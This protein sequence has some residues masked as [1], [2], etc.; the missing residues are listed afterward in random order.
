MLCYQRVTPKVAIQ[1]M[2]E[3]AIVRRFKREM[4]QNPLGDTPLVKKVS[5]KHEPVSKRQAGFKPDETP[6]Y[7]VEYYPDSIR[8]A[9]LQIWRPVREGEEHFREWKDV[10]SE[11]WEEYDGSI[12]EIYDGLTPS[13]ISEWI[14]E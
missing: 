6:A 4:N 3:S 12:R 8:G 9:V 2:T 10:T 11:A 1:T 13:N 7:V 14:D 5:Y